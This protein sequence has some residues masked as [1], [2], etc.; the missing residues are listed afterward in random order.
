[1]QWTQAQ[2]EWPSSFSSSSSRHRDWQHFR[3]TYSQIQSNTSHVLSTHNKR[4]E[5]VLLFE[6]EKVEEGRDNNFFNAKIFSRNSSLPTILHASNATLQNVTNLL[7][8]LSFVLRIPTDS[9]RSFLNIF[10]AKLREEPPPSHDDIKPLEKKKEKKK[11]SNP[12]FSRI[13]RGILSLVPSQ[14]PRQCIGRGDES[15]IRRATC[16]CKKETRFDGCTR[17]WEEVNGRYTWKI[18]VGL[19]ARVGSL[20]DLLFERDA[21]F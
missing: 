18:V 13:L 16:I 6:I 7:E 12:R 21:V 4:K 9:T 10:Q 3:D 8:F 19:S 11:V 1:M 17:S 20:R 15:I 14:N 5:Y 2:V